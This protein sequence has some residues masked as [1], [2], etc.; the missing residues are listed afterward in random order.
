MKFVTS[1]VGGKAPGDGAALSI[2]LSLQGGNTL[3]QVLHTCHATRQTASCKDT[4]LDLGHIQ[5]TAMF[6][7]VM[8]LHAPQDA[9]RLG[10]FKGFI[11][12][13]S[14]MG[15]QVILHNANAGGVRI[16]LVDQPLDAVRVVDLGAVLRHLDM[17]PSSQRRGR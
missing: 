15:V 4:N 1:I 5:P 2:A 8:K 6:G 13:S 14:G 10:G 7:R 16:D 3:T 9:P 12:G 17:A 11:Q